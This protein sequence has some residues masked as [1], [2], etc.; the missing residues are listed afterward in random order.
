MPF[1]RGI[2]RSV[3]SGL[4]LEKAPDSHSRRG[5]WLAA[6]LV[7]LGLLVAFSLYLR[8]LTREMVISDARDAVTLAVGSCVNRIVRE[9]DYSYEDFV[10]LEKDSEGNL[11]A[12]TT[13]AMRVNAFSSQLLQEISRSAD[14][15]A[16]RL[17]IPLGNLLGSDLLMGRGPAIP[18]D[19]LMLTSSFVQLDN[20][21]TSTGINQSRHAI[22]LRADVDIEILLPWESIQTTVESDVMIAETVIVGRV[23]QTYVNLTE[24][25]HGRK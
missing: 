6:V 25:D 23:P 12:I 7:P 14:D 9:N 24:E 18:I 3:Y 16:L 4:S 13:D 11:T 22:T 10:T 8:S 20:E 2:R 15:E 5:V 21:L 19:I 1:R 17:R